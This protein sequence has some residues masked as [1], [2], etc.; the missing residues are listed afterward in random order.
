M[1]NLLRP[2]RIFVLMLLFSF[3]SMSAVIFTPA[4]P[5]LVREFHL[6]ESSAQ[7]MMTL[8][9]L[10]TA[11]GRLPYGPL[12]NRF[13]RKKALFAG[14]W[15]SLIGTVF[16]LFA[17]SYAIL[18]IGRL[19][20]ALG[21]SAALKI[22]Y[23]MVGDRHSEET[24]TKVLS[25][26]SLAYA[27][28][29]GIG[30]AISGFLTASYGWRGGFGCLFVFTLFLLAACASLP[31]TLVRKDETALQFKKMAAG[32]GKQFRNPL[33]WAWSLL[34]GLS[35]AILFMFSQQAPFVAIEIMGLRPDQYGLFYLIPAFGIAF[36]TF[37]TA[38]MS[39]KIS[40]NKA[41]LLGILILVIGTGSMIGF[42]SANWYTGWTLFLP[43]V[44]VQI[45]DAVLYTNASSKAIS[46]AKD[47]SNASAVM[48]F[49]NSC[50][51]V[52]G[53]YLIGV[54]APLNAISLPLSFIP[55]IFLMLLIWLGLRPHCKNR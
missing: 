46:E 9:L 5:Q 39:G 45:G 48:L 34:M 21:S 8:F 49:I 50:C 11:F 14:L 23:T 27:I 7:W 32:Y 35:T 2:S 47:K 15:L 4:Y 51:G 24:A 13:G 54:Y 16:T 55:I 26:S 31:E 3:S 42:F 40:A 20:Q 53:T 19:I 43:Q 18:C 28:L 36:G 6:S 29:P 37:L 1:P 38:W 22:T 30:T 41:M 10:G 52:V 44:V 17:P 25:Y 33:L 12:A